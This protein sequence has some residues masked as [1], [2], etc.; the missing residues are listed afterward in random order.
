VVL[1]ASKKNSEA[2]KTSSET[3]QSL[4]KITTS[5]DA[6]LSYDEYLELF[7]FMSVELPKTQ[8]IELL[9]NVLRIFFSN[10]TVKGTPYGKL[11][12]QKQWSVTNHCLAKPYDQFVK[13]GQFSNSQRTDPLNEPVINALHILLLN[14]SGIQSRLK[15]LHL[16]LEGIRSKPTTDLQFLL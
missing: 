13:N 6:I 2:Q 3:T 8:N 12:K 14:F 9:D 16:V 10:F 11:Q 5:K 7:K 15:S 1:V 4:K